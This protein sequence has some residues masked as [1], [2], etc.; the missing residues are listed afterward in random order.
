MDDAAN[1]AVGVRQRLQSPLVDR[2]SADGALA[3][4]AAL[5]PFE[6]GVDPQERLAFSLAEALED[7]HGC[8][9]RGGVRPV[10]LPL[11][12]QPLLVRLDLAVATQQHDSKSEQPAA[13]S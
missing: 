4:A 3:V 12:Q 13:E 8:L 9:V 5:H 10:D 1:A 6:R 2:L 11:G 7:G